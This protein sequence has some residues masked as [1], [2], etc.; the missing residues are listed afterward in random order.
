MTRVMDIVD[1]P[2]MISYLRSL[3]SQLLTAISHSLSV[4]GPRRDE[5][6][7]RLERSDFWCRLREN[8]SR[9]SDRCGRPL[10]GRSVHGGTDGLNPLSSRGESPRSCASRAFPLPPFTPA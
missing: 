5:I 4:H 10:R 8:P 2:N 7:P 6:E 1:E 3:M 9:E